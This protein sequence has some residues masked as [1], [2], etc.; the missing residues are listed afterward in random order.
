[1]KQENEKKENIQSRPPIVVVLGHVDHGK[2]TILDF[3]R[4]TKV[5]EKETGGITQHIGAYEIEHK[6]KRITFIDT[7]GH[8]V[9]SAMRSRGAK[10]ADIAILVVAAEEG[11]KPQTKE[12]I[13]YIKKS[14]VPMIVAINKIDKSEADPERVK[15]ELSQNEVLVESMG[16]KI[17]QVLVSGKTG[18]GIDELL[19]L[20]LL[21]AEMENLKGDT[22]KAGEGVVIEAYLDKNRG[23]T[24]T[25]LLK[26]GIL[27]E[28]DIIVTRS[29]LGKI[30]ILEDFQGKPLKEI[31]PS[32]PCIVIGFEKVPQVGEKFE[33]SPDIESAQKYIEKKERKSEGGEVLFIEEGKKVLNLILKA[34][35]QGSIEAIEEIIKDLPQEKVLLRVLRSEVGEINENDI[36]LAKS[37][38]A[39]IMGFRIRTNPIAV[40][41]AERDNVKIIAFDII[42]ELTQAVRQLMEKSLEPEKFRN[43]LG[44]IKIITVFLTEKNRQIAG[45][46][47]IGG[48]IKK[49][50]LAEVFRRDELLGKGKIINLQKNKK[51]ADSAKKG[52]ECGIMYEGDVKIEEGDLLQVFIEERRKGEL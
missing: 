11:V 50:T 29:A 32:M 45:G 3:I 34:D 39:K 17:P 8:E 2:T 41:L 49:G 16:G 15:R 40:K 44:K 9:F 46:K 5:A 22:E 13:S 23:P 10:V 52:E 27:K 30:K 28:G 48:E 26:D 37:S 43:D 21:V 4:K 7:P 47:I 20:I 12:A 42:Y 38:Q 31:L 25:L 24:A 6:E 33:V 1:M 14:G 35:V 18:K 36:S 51:S 19:E